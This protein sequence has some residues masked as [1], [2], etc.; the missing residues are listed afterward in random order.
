MQA[1]SMSTDRVPVLDI[2]RKPASGEFRTLANAIP[3][4]LWMTSPTGENSFINKPLA[5]FLGIPEQETLPE[6]AYVIHPEDGPRA[7]E[8]FADCLARRVEHTDEHR[9]RR[10]D[11]QYCW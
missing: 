7:R 5:D 10:F 1:R 8:N 9:V 3:A 2:E 4:L 6:G 11:G